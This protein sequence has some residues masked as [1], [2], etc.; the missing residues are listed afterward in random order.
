MDS[1]SS[2]LYAQGSL[3]LEQTCG[4]NVQPKNK[5]CTGKKTALTVSAHPCSEYCS[6]GRVVVSLRSK[7]F[8]ASS[9]RTFSPLPL[10]LPPF[11]FSLPL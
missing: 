10:P 6:S 1:Y 9:S 7:R 11:F 2:V 3:K 8:R 4:Y 5:V